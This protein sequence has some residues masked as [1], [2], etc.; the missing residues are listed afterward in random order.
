MPVSCVVDAAPDTPL[1]GFVAAVN[2]VAQES[3]QQTTRRFFDVIIELDQ[4]SAAVL[5]PG[6]SVQVDVVMRRADDVLVAPRAALDL[7]AD[8]PRAHLA[9]GRDVEIEI[10]FCDAQV[11][12]IAAG[13]TDGDALR[14]ALEGP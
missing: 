11:C 9:D 6:L 5:R 4:T 10:D 12:A 8:P 14:G 13:L 1:S 7:A 3:A 2:P